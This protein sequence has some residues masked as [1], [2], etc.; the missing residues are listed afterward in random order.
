[1]SSGKWRPFCLGLNVLKQLQMMLA[2]LVKKK[3]AYD[4][5]AELSWHVQISG[6]THEW[7]NLQGT[8]VNDFI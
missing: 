4:I 5:L 1:M 7:F 2:S 3:K 8:I 6:E